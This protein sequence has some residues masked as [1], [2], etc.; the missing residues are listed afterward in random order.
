MRLIL[1]VMFG[2]AAVMPMS[3]DANAAGK[4]KNKLCTGM[5]L[6]NKKVSFKCKASEKCCFD[7]L[8]KKGTCV[9]ANA[10]CL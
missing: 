9:A 1:A 5:A 8:A 2:L 6:D 10:V 7:A 4:P 3:I